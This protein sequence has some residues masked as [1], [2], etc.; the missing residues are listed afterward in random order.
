MYIEPKTNI[1]ILQNV[2]LDNTYK[3]TIYF[4]NAE[5]QTSYFSGLTKFNLTRQSYQRKERGTMRIQISAEKLYNCNYLMFQ[6]SS[7]E[8]QKWFYAFITSVEYVSN[9]VSEVGFEIDVMQTWFFDVTL[10]D[11]FVEREHSKTD[12]MGENIVPEPINIGEYYMGTPSK[13]GYF[14]DFDCVIVSPYVYNVNEVISPWESNT[15]LK[16]IDHN[17]T[18]LCHQAFNSTN[19]YMEEAPF[20]F[21]GKA[22]SQFTHDDDI[23]CIYLCPHSF[24]NYPSTSPNT[25]LLDGIVSDKTFTVNSNKPTKLSHGY[26]PRNKKLLTFPFNKLV[27]DTSDG[28]LYDYMYEFFSSYQEGGTVYNSINFKIKGYRGINNSFKAVPLHYKGENENYTEGC[29]LTDFPNVGFV[30]DSFKAWV[31]QN[32]TRLAL[33]VGTSLVGVGSGLGTVMSGAS[34]LTPKTQVLSKKGAETMAQGYEQIGKNGVR[35][36]IGT[37]AEGF[38]RSALRYHPRSG[39][40]DGAL[41]IN[42]Y[43]KD[44]NSIQYSVNPNDAKIIDEFFDVYG[45]ATRRVKKPNRNVRPHWTYTKTI[46]CNIIGNA[47]ADD[48]AK[49][50]SIYDSGI[51]FW[52]NGN[53][54][55][56][57]SLNNQV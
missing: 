47:P 49:I 17:P 42:W 55:G 43:K 39:S 10:K 52:K 33:Q 35:G 5:A 54:V 36:V 7:F 22:L 41:E 12:V 27:I 45:Y 44:F 26:T 14:N 3:H 9:E 2:P 15:K 29:L 30:T 25:V 53:E 23:V 1:R 28:N 31:A 6:N 38:D 16:S 40:S 8:P 46:D 50:C 18:V 19:D 24:I 37:L 11:S 48:V 32:K 13:S 56:N 57:Y 34:M 21:L 4:A 20:S 51:T